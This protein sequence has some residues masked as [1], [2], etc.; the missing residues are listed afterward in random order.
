[1]LTYE[2]P[3]TFARK[4]SVDSDLARDRL[5]SSKEPR[6]TGM[7]CVV[8]DRESVCK[9]AV[10]VVGRERGEWGFSLQEIYG[11]RA[12]SCCDDWTFKPSA[13]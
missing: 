6:T 8:V 2:V 12:C 4:S 1:M 10:E 11:E 9:V 5:R 3:L 7:V 13:A